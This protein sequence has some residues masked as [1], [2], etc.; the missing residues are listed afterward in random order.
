MVYRRWF[1]NDN[2]KGA[3][4]DPIPRISRRAYAQMLLDRNAPGDRERAAEQG[5]KR[6]LVLH[7]SRSFRELWLGHVI[8][9]G[10]SDHHK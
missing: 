8:P 4:I 1:A 9:R 5:A 7:R 3:G 10:A 6:W 2:N